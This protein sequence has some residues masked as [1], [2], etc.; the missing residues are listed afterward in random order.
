MGAKLELRAMGTLMEPQAHLA[1]M[2]R[3]RRVQVEA[4]AAAHQFGR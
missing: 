4:F 1:W 2:R 3:W